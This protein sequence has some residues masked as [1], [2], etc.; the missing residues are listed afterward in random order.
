MTTALSLLSFPTDV[1]DDVQQKQA[2]PT[3]PFRIHDLRNHE[4]CQLT[5]VDLV[6]EVLGQYVMLPYTT[7]ATNV[8]W[9]QRRP[10][11]DS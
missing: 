3:V 9:N 6:Q 7:T 11:G 1:P 4:K 8:G 10:E 2:I 5:A